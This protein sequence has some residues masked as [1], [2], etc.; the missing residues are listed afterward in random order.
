MFKYGQRTEHKEFAP[1]R[2]RVTNYV[3]RP[4]PSKK[5]TTPK[6]EPVRSERPITMSAEVRPITQDSTVRFRQTANRISTGQ[7]YNTFYTE[8]GSVTYYN[9]E[10]IEGKGAYNF[11]VP[12][13][14]A[15]EQRLEKLWYD[16]LNKQINEKR[17]NEEMEQ[18]LQE[19][20]D[21]K[22]RI[23]GEL[24]R[25]KEQMKQG[26][27]NF[28]VRG[29]TR[30][31][32]PKDIEQSVNLEVNPL[33]QSDG[34]SLLSESELEGEESEVSSDASDKVPRALR[35]QKLLNKK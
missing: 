28:N 4:M 24:H 32:R 13:D 12:T 3:R 10:R 31:T 2:D 20:K 8:K 9:Q 25:R 11:Y 35:I 1:A 21:A 26:N 22:S 33:E 34:S 23:E 30:S 5:P 18:T 27:T 29:F 6:K 19:W 17:T 14:T 7:T 15:L 16:N